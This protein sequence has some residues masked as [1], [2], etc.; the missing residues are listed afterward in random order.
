MKLNSGKNNLT[1]INI[2]A[3]LL[4]ILAV[5]LA[6]RLIYWWFLIQ[7]FPIAYGDV[8]YFEGAHSIA[9]SWSYSHGGKLTASKSP[10]YPVFAGLLL[11]IF[12]HT[13]AVILVQYLFGVLASLPIYFIARRYLSENKSILIVLAYLI[14]PTTWFWES[15]FMSESLYVWLNIL[16]IFFI[17]RYMLKKKDFDLMAGSFWGAA[18]FLTRPAAVFPLSAVFI[19][20]IY[21]NRHKGVLKISAIWCFTFLIV[22]SP[23]IIR[24]YNVF[25]KFIPGSNQAGVTIYTSYVNWGRDMSSVNYLPEDRIVLSNL[26]SEAEKNK[27]LLRR[28]FDYLKEN[29][30]KFITLMPIKLIHYFHPFDGRWYPLSLGSKFNPFYGLL[31]CFALLGFWWNRKENTNLIKLSVPFIIGAVI[32]VVIFHGEIRYRF[33]LNPVFFLIAA[34]CFVKPLSSIKMKIILSI[35]LFNIIFW[36]IGT[37]IR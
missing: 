4:F 28:T 34:F 30:S 18:S 25:G 26:E 19:S 31:A 16:F 1:F 10:G 22:L 17:H 36:G 33:V 29:P 14:Y 9:E 2:P 13:Q 32:S 7:P 8:T 6:V 23:W 20:L 15:S 37:A 24:N 11:K 5:S 27:F 3:I 12:G 21:Q 35:I